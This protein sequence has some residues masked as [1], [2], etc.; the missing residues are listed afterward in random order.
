M[1]TLGW[2]ILAVVWLISV[3]T[4]YWVDIVSYKKDNQPYTVGRAIV[5]LLVG[6]VGCG[7]LLIMMWCTEMIL[8]ILGLI[9][10][11]IAKLVSPILK[12]RIL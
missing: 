3:V 9:F 5:D 4:V 11:C 12:K 2:I 6:S 8:I 1:T 7:L 10:C